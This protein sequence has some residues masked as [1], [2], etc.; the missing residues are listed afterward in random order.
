ME[1]IT[2]IEQNW[3]EPT[4]PGKHVDLSMQNGAQNFAG[5]SFFLLLHQPSL[6]PETISRLSMCA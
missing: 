4:I 1:K 3:F 5:H 2:Q 6:A